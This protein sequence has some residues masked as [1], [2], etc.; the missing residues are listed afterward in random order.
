MLVHEF[1]A[2]ILEYHYY[3]TSGVGLAQAVCGPVAGAA[4]IGGLVLSKARLA[5]LE[6]QVP[7]FATLLARLIQ[8]GLLA[9]LHL[10]QAYL[11]QDAAARYQTLLRHQPEVAYRVPQHML[12]SY[13]QVT[14]QSL[15]RLRKTQR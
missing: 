12:A 15:S 8:Q 11:G 5:V 3:Q 9:K 2:A 14:P 4:A 7:Y 1:D 10:R 6:Q 13:L